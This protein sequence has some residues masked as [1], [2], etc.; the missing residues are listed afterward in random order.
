MILRILTQHKVYNITELSEIS[1]RQSASVND[2]HADVHHTLISEQIFFLVATF[3][4]TALS[5]N[6]KFHE[7]LFPAMHLS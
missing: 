2:M 3:V 6:R 1:S 4:K 5:F 7:S